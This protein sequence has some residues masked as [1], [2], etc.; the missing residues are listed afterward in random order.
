MNRKEWGKYV[1]KYN[2]LEQTTYLNQ[3]SKGFLLGVLSH[4]HSKATL[5]VCS[6]VIHNKYLD[7][8]VIL[9]LV[10]RLILI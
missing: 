2:S 5:Y 3:L 1:K 8:K 9:I 7:F 6:H 10:F 4:I